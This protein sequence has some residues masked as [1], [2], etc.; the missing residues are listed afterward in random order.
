MFSRGETTRRGSA[1]EKMFVV[2]GGQVEDP[3]VHRQMTNNRHY[4][5]HQWVAMRKLE[6]LK[7]YDGEGR[8]FVFE[9]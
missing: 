5:L 3:N 4:V 6:I 7:F 9:C 8:V 2:D 1:S